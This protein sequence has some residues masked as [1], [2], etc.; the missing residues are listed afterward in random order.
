MRTTP[1]AAGRR[2]AL[3]DRLPT[4]RV[5]AAAFFRRD[6][7][8]TRS[9]RYPLVL[10]SLFALL[11]LAVTFYVSKTFEGI[12][13]TDLNGAPNYFAFAAVGIAIASVVETATTTVANRIRNGQLSGSL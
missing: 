8:I 3:A 12:S 13:P 10:D 1:I 6:L 9:F 2:S 5:V 4:V 11:Q 7:A